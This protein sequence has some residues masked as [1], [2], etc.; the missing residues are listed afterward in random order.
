LWRALHLEVDAPPPVLA[1]DV[2]LQLLEP[3]ESWRSRGDMHPDG[4]A[5][6]RAWVVARARFVED[7]VAAEA[8]VGLCQYVILGAGLDTFAQRR[9]D[10][11]VTVYEVDQPDPQAWKRQRL[12]DL[13]FGV[14]DRLRLVAFDFE[15]TGSWWDALVGAGF[16]PARPAVLVSTGVSMY[17]TREATSATLREV[18]R[19]APGSAFAMT[20]QLTDDLLDPADRAG[21]AMAE[22][23]AAAAGTPFLSY[24]TREEI[25]ALARA[26]GFGNVTHVTGPDLTRRYFAGRTD[27]LRPSTGEDIL[28]ART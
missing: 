26:A 27:G 12:T 10:V 22:K 17:L 8:A 6:F 3:D 23:G 15:A 4:T 24:Y 7:L 11:E 21:R 25:E 9:S 2:G 20:Y 18:A 14:P 19:C 16:D 13:G 1:D 5:G 28:I